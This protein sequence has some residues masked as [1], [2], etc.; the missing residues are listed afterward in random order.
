MVVR[1]VFIIKKKIKNA[2][3]FLKEG[4]WNF[5]V[6]RGFKVIFNYL[7]ACLRLPPS[8]AWQKKANV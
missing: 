1:K 8:F 2:P 7:F 3:Q 4:S 5:A 6:F